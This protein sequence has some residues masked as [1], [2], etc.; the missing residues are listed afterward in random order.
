MRRL[1]NRLE[2]CVQKS[3]VRIKNEAEHER[4]HDEGGDV[5]EEKGD[6]VKTSQIGGG[7]D[8]GADGE[9]YQER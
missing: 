3:E 9:G 1:T 8:E 4:D 6:P 5:R 2:E 7:H